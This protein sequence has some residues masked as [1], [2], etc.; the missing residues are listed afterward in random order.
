MDSSANDGIAE[1][2]IIIWWDEDSAQ[3]CARAE[4]VSTMLAQG[5]GD[6]DLE[7]AS[8]LFS[9]LRGLVEHQQWH[10]DQGK[11][12]RPFDR[13]ADLLA[14]EDELM[15]GLFPRQSDGQPRIAVGPPTLDE[16]LRRMGDWGEIVRGAIE[17]GEVI[18]SK[19]FA[20]SF[21]R[22][23]AGEMEYGRA[24]VGEFFDEDGRPGE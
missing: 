1:K 18:P 17:R 20:V 7:A 6:S 23:T 5:A 11:P 8:C 4:G 14:R 19:V 3:W 21:R 2:D 15:T 13:A 22:L 16:A 9:E 24:L 12:V 10:L